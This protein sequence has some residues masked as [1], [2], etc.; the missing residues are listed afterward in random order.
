MSHIIG[1]LL[2]SGPYRYGRQWDL[3][4]LVR[5]GPRGPGRFS[6]RGFKLMREINREKS[7][8]NSP[9]RYKSPSA[10]A[11]YWLSIIGLSFHLLLE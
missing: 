5:R 2:A 3:P 9:R 4:N 11:G 7:L 8:K 6:R 1:T 10:L